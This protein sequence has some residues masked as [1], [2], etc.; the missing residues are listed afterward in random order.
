MPRRPNHD[1]RPPRDRVVH[2][3]L[4]K[5]HTDYNPLPEQTLTVQRA[6][7]P[8][9]VKISMSKFRPFPPVGDDAP[10]AV[11]SIDLEGAKVIVLRNVDGKFGAKLATDLQGVYGPDIL[12]GKGSK[13]KC[14][15]A[16]QHHARRAVEPNADTCSYFNDGF[17]KFWPL[18]GE[19]HGGN[20]DGD[21]EYAGYVRTFVDSLLSRADLK[22]YLDD[23]A[24]GSVQ[25]LRYRT[26]GFGSARR[27]RRARSSSRPRAATRAIGSTCTSTKTR[28]CPR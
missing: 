11:E 12:R 8:D 18:F 22:E 1:E 4:S 9:V 16:L 14:S 26:T 25:I 15:R 3:T 6:G 24:A 19:G 28:T 5:G 17:C 10:I 20:F 2:S 23:N 7:E 27:A 13:N 21:V